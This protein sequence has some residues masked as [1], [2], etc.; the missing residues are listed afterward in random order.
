MIFF[1]CLSRCC[2]S[3]V[4]LYVSICVMCFVCFLCAFLCD[5]CLRFCVCVLYVCLL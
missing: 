2:E 3:V 5:V 1:A 4:C